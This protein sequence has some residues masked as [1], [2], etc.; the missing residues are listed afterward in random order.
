MVMQKDHF[1]LL[2]LLLPPSDSGPAFAFGLA[3]GQLPAGRLS[4]GLGAELAAA[5]SGGGGP[6]L[7]GSLSPGEGG[8]LPLLAFPT[9]SQ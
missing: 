9:A 6:L 4:T 5:G 8:R 7:G 1:L 2:H 3:R